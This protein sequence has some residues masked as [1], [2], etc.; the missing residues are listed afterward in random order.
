MLSSVLTSDRAAQVN[1]ATAHDKI[2]ELGQG[3]YK[4]FKVVFERLDTVDIEIQEL[5]KEKQCLP[6]KR[7]KIGLK[8]FI[9]LFLIQTHFDF[10]K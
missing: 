5:K 1:L 8:S 3:T 7:K 9:N 2:D 10:Y 4:L 6:I